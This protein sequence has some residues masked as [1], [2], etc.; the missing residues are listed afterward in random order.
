[1]ARDE[2]DI[3]TRVPGVG[4]K[5]ARAVI[6]HLRDRLAALGVEAAPLLSDQDAEVI[7]ALTALGFSIVEAQTALQ[8][9]PRDVEMPL[10][11]RVRQALSYLAPG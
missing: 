7:G 5:T 2:P 8:S 9:L 3:L 11:E 1:V 4:P 6:F 10:E